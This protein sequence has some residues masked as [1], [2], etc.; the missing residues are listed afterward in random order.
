MPCIVVL[1]FIRLLFISLKYVRTVFIHLI[2]LYINYFF[3]FRCEF[4]NTAE[5]KQSR[6]QIAKAMKKQRQE[7]RKLRAAEETTAIRN[8]ITESGMDPDTMGND[9]GLGS[10]RPASLN[11][12]ANI[13]V[14]IFALCVLSTLSGM[15]IPGY[16][17]SVI[18]TIEKRF[19]IGSS[20][21][22]KRICFS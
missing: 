12:C 22:G 7:E 3:L 20:T 14:F 17:N 6:K 18:T 10:C 16:L 4:V 5:T 8:V 15:M 1:N 9:C 2:F 19:E 21:S 13:K 11:S